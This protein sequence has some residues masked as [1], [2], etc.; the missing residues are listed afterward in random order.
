MNDTGP[1]L[2]GLTGR[3]SVSA[4]I[5]LWGCR[6]LFLVHMWFFVT[7]IAVILITIAALL[8]NRSAGDGVNPD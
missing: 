8:A 1:G 5:C 4:P 3:Q 7:G 2:T 6:L